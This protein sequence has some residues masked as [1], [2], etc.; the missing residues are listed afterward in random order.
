MTRAGAAAAAASEEEGAARQRAWV[1][2]GGCLLAAGEFAA[3][4]VSWPHDVCKLPHSNLRPPQ[5]LALPRIPPPPARLTLPNRPL[6]PWASQAA[7]PHPVPHAS[8]SP[9]PSP[10]LSGL[11]PSPP[12]TP[13]CGVQVGGFFF[14]HRDDL[15]RVAPLWLQYTE[16]VR[17]DPEVQRTC[18]G[19]QEG[20]RI[21][22][23]RACCAVCQDRG[24]R[25]R[26]GHWQGLPAC[27]T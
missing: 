13:R 21:V 15:K 12:P 14:E 3:G 17:L 18:R 26:A 1:G 16:D 20:G 22:S 7:A 4:Q 27:G 5:A 10:S 6:T 24:R 11:L 23:C 19:S 2:G 25:G 8:P 9:F